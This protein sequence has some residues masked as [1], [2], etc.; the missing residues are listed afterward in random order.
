MVTTRMRWPADT[1]R[2]VM[3]LIEKLMRV[4]EGERGDTIGPALCLVCAFELCR[5]GGHGD[6]SIMI[7]QLVNDLSKLAVR[8]DAAVK[9]AAH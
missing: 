5:M 9:R 2:D 8:Y 4:L 1:P 7:E 3:T 6:D